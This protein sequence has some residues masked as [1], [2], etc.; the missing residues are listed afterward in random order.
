MHGASRTMQRI[1]AKR[2]K[3]LERVITR[4][5]GTYGDL[6]GTIGAS[7]KAIEKFELP[8]IE[9]LEQKPICESRP[10]KSKTSGALSILMYS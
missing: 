2:E 8:L 5:A 3:Q 10:Q 7:L 1:W 6:N 9:R 4:A